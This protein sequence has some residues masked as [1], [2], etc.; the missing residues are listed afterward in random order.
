M[1][2][3]R[4]RHGASFNYDYTVD[5]DIPSDS[6]S[7]RGRGIHARRTARTSTN[8]RHPKVFHYVSPPVVSFL[9]GYSRRNLMNHLSCYVHACLRF[10]GIF[11]IAR[12]WAHVPLSTPTTRF[13]HPIH[14]PDFFFSSMLISVF[15]FFFSKKVLA[16]N[17]SGVC[18]PTR[19]SSHDHG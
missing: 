1:N 11:S 13:F 3:A 15:F 8:S 2:L 14:P 4:R 5:Y 17:S 18:A 6:F 7:H 9:V 16:W 10:R 12:R 19:C